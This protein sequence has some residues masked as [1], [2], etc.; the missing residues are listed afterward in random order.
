MLRTALLSG[1]EDT[2][3][4]G[5]FIES[6]F[7]T[8]EEVESVIEALEGA[9]EGLSVPALEREVNVSR[10]RIQKAI[11][12]L[13]LESP[14]PIAKQDTRW[15][16]TAST[17]S[18]TFWERAQR[19]TAVREAEQDQMQ[20]YVNLDTGRMEFLIRALDGEPGEISPP[21]VP[22]LPTTVRPVLVQ[23][24]ITFLR[25]T[26]LPIE[27]RKKWPAGGLPIYGVSGLIE[28]DLRAQ[29]GKALCLW[30][31]AGWGAAV[32]NGKYRDGRFSDELVAASLDL[33]E[34]WAPEPAP[35]WVA[36]IPSLRHP[37]L[38][39][40]FARRLAEGL[41]IPFEPVLV[42]VEERPEQKDMA[43]SAQQARNVDGALQL[44]REKLQDEPVLLV[45]DM[46][47]SRWT[48]TVAGWL[49]R[50]HGSGEVWPFALAL[51]GGGA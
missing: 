34:E 27:P 8:P 48:L 44:T 15:Q 41:G 21:D 3:I 49:L 16:L 10:S 4:T 35:K 26:S 39:P 9:P 11:D 30:G 45:D 32:R 42:Q 29:R 40:D 51:A 1:E 19:L 14:A 24:A 31:D 13:S 33:I 43:N 6:S 25:R 20:E 2:E 18:A 37:E 28:T 36:C 23:E 50:N 47:D 5:Y 38:V 22:P 46:V 17:L 7:P 12:L